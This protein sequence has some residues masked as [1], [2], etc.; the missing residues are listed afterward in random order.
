MQ[1]NP[2]AWD[3]LANA[4]R[5]QLIFFRDGA[6]TDA[7]VKDETD[8]LMQLVLAFVEPPRG[9]EC[10]LSPNGRHQVDTSMES[11]PNNCFHCERPMK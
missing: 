2:I 7:Q 4:I 11:G 3:D 9:T 6:I 8:I 5:M 10:D 1:T